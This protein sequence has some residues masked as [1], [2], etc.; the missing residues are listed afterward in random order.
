[1]HVHAHMLR[2]VCEHAFHHTV[3]LSD[4]EERVKQN[5][6]SPPI[7]LGHATCRAPFH[8]IDTVETMS[9]QH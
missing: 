9:E 6:F 4:V 7:F 2:C 8:T 3:E 1:M 5:L